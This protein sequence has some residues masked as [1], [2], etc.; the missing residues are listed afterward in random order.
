MSRSLD[1]VQAQ[2]SHQGSCMCKSHMWK[3]LCYGLFMFMTYAMDA[4]SHLKKDSP[5]KTA[6][7]KKRS[8]IP[9]IAFGLPVLIRCAGKEKNCMPSSSASA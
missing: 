4:T 8:K 1:L 7:S 2:A 9:I 5:T 3:G 6:M